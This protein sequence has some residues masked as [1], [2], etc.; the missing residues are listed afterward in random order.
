MTAQVSGVPTPEVEWFR[1]G[2][3]IGQLQR[4]MHAYSEEISQ[5]G[6]PIDK[7]AT[8]TDSDARCHCLRIHS[9]KNEHVAVY[10][11]RARNHFGEAKKDAK[12]ELSPTAPLLLQP[13]PDR[14]K[15]K[16]GSQLRLEAKVV[17]HP[18]PCVQWLRNGLPIRTSHVQDHLSGVHSDSDR[19]AGSESSLAGARRLQSSG[20][21]AERGTSNQTVNAVDHQP[22]ECVVSNDIYNNERA[23]IENF[24]NGVCILTIEKMKDEDEGESTN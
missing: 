24:S 21:T 11:V 6:Q 14:V 2:V 22:I 12:L 1:N 17:G 5:V 18:M 20:G 9:V 8:S 16:E 4:D 10:S 3:A 19:A 15:V 7:S 13:L 23:K